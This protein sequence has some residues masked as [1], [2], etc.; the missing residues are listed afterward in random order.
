MP[1][2]QIV[3]PLRI[4]GKYLEHDTQVSPPLAD[5]SKLPWNDGQ[6]DINFD[7]P[8]VSD[9]LVHQPFE[10]SYTL[11]AGLH[12]HFILPHFLG[13]QYPVDSNETS[14]SSNEDSGLQAE[15]QSKMPAAPNRWIITK[16]VNNIAKKQWLVQSDYVFDSNETPAHNTSVIPIIGGK[17]YRYMGKKIESFDATNTDPGFINNFTKNNTNQSLLTVVGYGDINYSSFYPNCLGVFGLHDGSALPRGTGSATISYQIIGWVAEE[18]ND[19]LL[20]RLPQIAAKIKNAESTNSSLSPLKE[21]TDQIKKQFGIEVDGIDSLENLELTG[22]T[23]YC[24]VINFDVQN[25]KVSSPSKPTPDLKIAL[26]NTGTEALSAL[27]ADSLSDISDITK[28]DS[29]SQILNPKSTI[30]DQLEAILMRSKI[31]HLQIDTGPKFREARH[32]NGFKAHHAGHLWKVKAESHEQLS[33]NTEEE[34]IPALPPQVASLLNTLNSS[35]VAY[36]KATHEIKVLQQ[37]LHADWVKYMHARYPDIEGR[38]EYPSADHIQYFIENYSMPELAPLLAKTGTVVYQKNTSGHPVPTTQSPIAASLACDLISAWTALNKYLQKENIKR[39]AHQQP[40]LFLAMIAGPRYWEAKAPVILFSGLEAENMPNET[41]P[42]K[43]VASIFSLPYAAKNIPSQ[44]VINELTEK[45]GYINNYADQKWTPFMMDWSVDVVDTKLRHSSGRFGSKKL[46]D[47]FV[48]NTKSPDFDKGSNYTP[49]RLSVFSGSVL[50]SGHAKLTLSKKIEDFFTVYFSKHK[51]TFYDKTP[52]SNGAYSLQDFLNGLE[53]LTNLAAP[54]SSSWENRVKMLDFSSSVSKL[55][56]FYTQRA[57]ANITNLYFTAWMAYNQLNQSQNIEERYS[58]YFESKDITF[59]S[60]VAPSSGKYTVQDFLNATAPTDAPDANWTLAVSMLDLTSSSAKASD[61]NTQKETAN[62][63]NLYF[64]AWQAYNQSKFNVLSQT[65]DGFNEACVMMKKTAQLPIAE[66]IGFNYEKAFSQNVN[67]LVQGKQH[68]SPIMA[69]EFNPIRSGALSLNMLSLIDNFGVSHQVDTNHAAI[70]SDTMQDQNGNPFLKP[71]IAQPARLNL[72]WSSATPVDTVDTID[73]NDSPDTSPICGWLMADY[74]NGDVMVYD[75]AGAA[76]GYVSQPDDSTATSTGIW[77]LVPWSNK[78]A[79]ID[80]DITNPH[81][82]KVVELLC[83]TTNPTT[84]ASSF[85]S[86]FLTST[87]HALDNIAPANANIYDVKSILMGRPMA[88]VR[89]RVSYE[90]MGKPVLDQSWSSLLT[91]LTN[92][93]KQPSWYYEDR[94]KD[95]WDQMLFPCRLGEY[96]QLNDGL[97]GYWMEKTDGSLSKTF[98]SPEMQ[99][100]DVNDTHFTGMSGDVYPVQWLKPND[101]PIHMTMLM[102]P[103]GVLH[104]TT[105]LLPTKSISIPPE[106]YLPAMQKIEM[107][108][109][110]FPILQP[111]TSDNK[112]VPIHVP[113][114]TGY[115]WQWWDAYQGTKPISKESTTRTNHDSSKIIDGWLSLTPDSNKKS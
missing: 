59:N 23:L 39:T 12:L 33:T 94:N 25:G 91:D 22:K 6:S 76:L 73:T 17:P 45:A 68:S 95:G 69:F 98:I 14:G 105:G 80:T 42:C 13:K 67:A 10:N 107:W 88:V 93:N 24:G 53:D 102:D 65:L 63:T 115:Q 60:K 16:R 75:A 99:S 20:N 34:A 92:C 32:D 48:F 82:K 29:G 81:L 51:I 96:R 64:K 9:G 27:L 35:Q 15:P 70:A 46:E 86:D 1:N 30:E 57:N 79:H 49:G 72:R 26:G 108:F 18:E 114:I 56:D 41:V 43:L 87:Q 104:A 21:F 71:R 44:S 8:F 5:F 61:F 7:Q 90:L 97:V 77:N 113:P 84:T 3:V 103:R 106:H 101:P 40:Q 89:S 47:N 52:A 62:N 38:G 78:T 112:S 37:Q 28:N 100:T 54:N 19:I 58:T 31:D 83:N 36:D 109:K 50:M 111:A 4:E 110:S 11:N 2:N 55:S 85:V 74:L 66:P